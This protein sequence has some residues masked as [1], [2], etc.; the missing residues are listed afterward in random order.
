VLHFARIDAG[1]LELVPVA[2]AVADIFAGLQPLIEPQA[3]KRGVDLQWQGCAPDVAVLADEDRLR[4]VMLNPLSNAVKFTPE[5]GRVPVSCLLDEARVRLRVSDTGPGIEPEHAARVFDPFVQLERRL[6]NPMDGTGLGFAIS[7][8]LAEAMG[9][10]I[11]LESTPGRGATF[12]LA[13]PHA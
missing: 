6:S 2:I 13:L 7:R 4:Q 11:T 8:T 5:G 10:G 1:H 9:G 12:T 3:R